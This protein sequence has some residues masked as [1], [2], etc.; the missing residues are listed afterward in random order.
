[1]FTVPFAGW[2]VYLWQRKQLR[3]TKLINAAELKTSTMDSFHLK[4]R[5]MQKNI[6]IYIVR[7]SSLLV[8]HR[9]MLSFCFD[10]RSRAERLKTFPVEVYNKIS[11]GQVAETEKEKDPQQALITLI[12]MH[13]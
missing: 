3:G 10:W 4:P 1:M 7:P 8:L 9:A 11:S 12:N 5:S 13:L 2:F 6:Y